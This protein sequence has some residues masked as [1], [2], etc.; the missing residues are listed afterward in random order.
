MT[1][2]QNID[3]SQIENDS[4][5]ME[6]LKKAMEEIEKLKNQDPEDNPSQEQQV[7][8]QQE[9]VDDEGEEDS[10]KE[11]EETDEEN[12]DEDE[13]EK[14]WRLKRD[15][16]RYLQ[17]KQNLAREN[18]RLRQIAQE[19][20]SAGTYHYSKSAHADLEKAKDHYRRAVENGDVDGLIEAN[21]SLAKAQNAVIEAE[22]WN[23]QQQQV[24]R[25]PQQNT[26]PN[27]ADENISN[28]ELYQ[29]IASDWIRGHSYLRRD[30]KNYNP[31]LHQ[32]VSEFINRLDSEIASS[33]RNDVYFTPE[34]FNIIDQHIKSIRQEA[35]KNTVRTNI[36]SSAHIG[37]VR[38]STT[39]NGVAKTTPKQMT[40]SAD[41][42]RMAANAGISEKE[43]LKYKL[44]DLKNKK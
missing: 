6:E 17:E 41:E 22:K 16:Y 19:S 23:S 4:S 34:Y 27:Y 42:R 40:L 30:S 28:D 36:E 25:Q 13:N 29:E 7:E 9:I 12:D 1:L 37:G 14:L 44:D 11:P 2:E 15:K 3:E 21:I 43:W 8:E 32:Q 33:G 31:A 10:Q 5:G 20:L 18:A 26:Q 38:K 24:S 35:T 39:A